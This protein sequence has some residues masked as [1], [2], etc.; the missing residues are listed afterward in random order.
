MKVNVTVQ[1]IQPSVGDQLSTVISYATVGG[2][3]YGGDDR[4]FDNNVTPNFKPEKYVV[5]EPSLTSLV[6]NLLM[7]TIQLIKLK[8]KT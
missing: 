4:V 1:V 3:A 2:D 8:S 6:T 7:T 5:S